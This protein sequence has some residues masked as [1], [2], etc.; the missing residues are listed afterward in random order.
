MRRGFFVRPELFFAAARRFFVVAFAALFVF[1]GTPLVASAQLSQAQQNSEDVA[2]A[3]GITGET[4]LP[5]IIGRIINIFLGFLGVVFLVLLIY[6]GYLWMTS[7]GDATK[8]QQAQNTIRNAVIGLIIIASAW[9]ITAFIFSWLA[10]E[11]GPGGGLGGGGTGGGG[12]LPGSAGSLGNGII[13]YHLPQR[14]ATGVPRNTPIIIT[15]KEPINPDSF[16][17][18]GTGQ[19]SSTQGVRTENIRIFR[20]STGAGTALASNQA[21]V[22]YTADKRTFVIKPLEYLGSSAQNVNYSVELKGGSNGIQKADGTAAFSGSFGSGYAWQFEVSTVV[23]L[24]PPQVVA[25]IPVAGGQYARNIIVQINFNE[26]V[27]PTA[28]TGKTLDGFTNIQVLSGPPGDPNAQPVAGEYRISNQYR[29]VE[30][31]PEAKCGTNSCGRDVF[32][33]PGEQS[34]QTTAKSADIDPQAIPQAIF[35]NNGYNGVV[36]VAGNS[37]DGDKS[38]TGQGPPT[39]N[40][41]WTF[42]TTNDVKLTPPQIETTVPSSDPQSG[43]NS[44]VPVDQPVVA[45]MDSLLQASSINSESAFID[46]H[47]AD[48]NDPD[49]FWWFSGMRLLTSSGAEYDPNAAPPQIPAKAAVVIEHRLYQPSGTGVQNLNY[50]DPYIL[51]GVQDVYQNCFNP[52]AVCGNGIGTPNCCNGS[53]NSNPLGCK[54]LLNP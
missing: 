51:S 13:E 8:V 16:I 17:E 15:F 5:T 34:I 29:T 48:E 31:I 27:D 35:T 20:T 28:T 14:N 36:D 23:D 12:G 3:A 52:A 7:G 22:S 24:T 43:G 21:R 10:S 32:C 38:G 40:F 26:A 6:A 42:G 33:L 53:P 47:G 49:T 9:A 37:L 25:A 11:G 41:T 39:D 4:D 50:Y 19:T 30:F 18:P 54:P 1:L 44:N 46:P 45:S 2:I